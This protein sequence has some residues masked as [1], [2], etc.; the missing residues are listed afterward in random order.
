MAHEL[1]Q[2]NYI[3]CKIDFLQHN[4]HFGINK[5]ITHRVNSTYQLHSSI[6]SAGMAALAG[7]GLSS[8]FYDKERTARTYLIISARAWPFPPKQY[9]T[10]SRLP[11]TDL[12]LELHHAIPGYSP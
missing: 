11:R 7:A 2:P 4:C 3:V 12:T 6:L 5:R 8:V 10:R 9:L 1:M